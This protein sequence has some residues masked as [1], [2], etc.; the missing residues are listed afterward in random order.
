MS[1]NWSER[2]EEEENSYPARSTRSL[3]PEQIMTTFISDFKSYHSSASKGADAQR[4][5]AKNFTRCF[6]WLKHGHLL[7]GKEITYKGLKT[8]FQ[9]NIWTREG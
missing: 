4:R 2:N 6:A 3:L 9:E 1:Q 8:K 5:G 7:R